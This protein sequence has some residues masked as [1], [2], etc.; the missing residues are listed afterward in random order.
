[1]DLASWHRRFHPFYSCDSL[2]AI[3]SG[4]RSH[5]MS[6]G[7]NMHGKRYL[8]PGGDTFPLCWGHIYGYGAENKTLTSGC[9][10]KI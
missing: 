10:D 7:Y 2:E 4:D 3:T 9:E 1:M 8:N 5:F 6:T